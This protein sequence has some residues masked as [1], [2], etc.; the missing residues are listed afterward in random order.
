[1]GARR[2]SRSEELLRSVAAMTSGLDARF[3]MR[4]RLRQPAGVTDTAIVDEASAMALRPRTRTRWR[5][6]RAKVP[7]IGSS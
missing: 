1:M 5:N 2:G 4:H 7:T 6:W 3:A